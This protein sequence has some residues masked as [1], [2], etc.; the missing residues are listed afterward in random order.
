MMAQWAQVQQ[1]DS[2]YGEQVYQLYDETFPMEVRQY[3]S[4]WIE[5]HDWEMVSTSNSLATV[6]FHDL[7]S[8][9]DDQYSHFALENNLLAQHNIRRIKRNLQE[10][11]QE[12]PL[13]LALIIC[14]CLKEEKNILDLVI[15]TQ[16]N[17]GFTPNNVVFEKQKELDNK[18]KSLTSKFQKAQQDIKS[19]EDLQDEHDFKKKTLQNRVEQ[20]G[21]MITKSPMLK[22]E[23]HEEE[24]VIRGLFINLNT[25]RE[26]VVHELADILSLA[27]DIQHTLVEEEIPE[28]KHRQQIACIGGPP[29][30]SLDQ[31]QTWFTAVAEGL[32]QVRQQLKKLQEL[33]QKYTYENDPITQYKNTLEERA[34]SL[35]KNLIVNSLVVERQPCMLSHPQ[36]PLV[37]KTGV[38]FTVKIRLLVK[39]QE[40]NYHF[41]V[42]AL[43]GKNVS[44]GSTVK[45]HFS[46]FNILGTNNK[47]MNME[48]SNGSLV[49]EFRHMQIKKT[50]VK[51]S[52]ECPLIVTEELHYMTFET[53]LSQPDLQVKLE[54]MSLPFVVISH[55]NQLPSAWAS[56]M[57]YNML[58]REPKNLLFFLN[59]PQA[60]WRQLSEVLSW[61]FSFVTKRGLNDEQLRMLGDKL[62]G[63]EAAGNPE[64]LIP[65]AK[66]CKN[67]KTLSFWLWIAAIL[68]LIKNHL[69]KLWDE[70]FIMGFVSKERE[71]AL[72]K[73]KEPG[74]FL[75]RFSESSREGAITFTWVEHSSND[76]HF[77]SV[78]PYTKKELAAISFADILHNY[79]VMAAE[80]I[81]ENPLLYLYPNIPKDSAFARH[82][83]RPTEAAE[84][85][86]FNS[87]AEAGYI[88]TE[89]ISVSEV[90]PSRL[91]DTMLPMSPEEYGELTRMIN[92][93]EIESMVQ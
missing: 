47:V 91:K 6:R 82:Y 29:N 39:L 59:P 12:D 65:W 24:M 52:N 1:L 45:G 90:H 77:H 18:V 84:E 28:W 58:T 15:Q 64:G 38:Q 40:F 8:Q 5:S 21:I 34:L 68:D 92:P 63:R 31:L 61:Q 81:P 74:T 42:K 79:K 37:L 85:M 43:F 9:L 16:D 57:W 10:N 11:F 46:K 72:L 3:L 54:T 49:A 50:T 53:H 80:N 75:L 25:T 93:A 87:G 32:Q 56:V 71:K 41:K 62:L 7:L 89:L 26:V 19:L 66:F 27:E 36:R 69:L 44:D 78:E 2:R 35:F 23:I 13:N 60:T 20:E 14:N 86:E 88:K 55:I 33:E 51:K 30:A 67:E 70:G 83:S 73:D 17:M 48:E 22:K 4:A 76:V